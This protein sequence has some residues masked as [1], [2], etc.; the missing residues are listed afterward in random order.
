MHQDINEQQVLFLYKHVFV[1]G[2]AFD[3][4]DDD[5]KNEAGSC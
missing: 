1:L 4:D 2:V 3:D 5:D